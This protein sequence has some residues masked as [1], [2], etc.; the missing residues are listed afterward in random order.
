MEDLR[1][2]FF[3]YAI[4]SLLM[5]VACCRFFSVKFNK[6]QILLVTL[7]YGISIWLVRGL[8]ALFHIPY[9]SHSLI[10]AFIFCMLLL[11]ITKQNLIYC[12]GMTC[13]SFSLVFLGGGLV[14]IG[15]NLTGLTEEHIFKNIWL[16]V[17]FGQLENILLVI[18]LTFDRIIGISLNSMVKEI[19]E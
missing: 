2:L 1:V 9:G 13:F 10:L 14:G 16:H 3:F 7:S 17:I 6:H 19:H 15:L 12:L 8:Y 5:T 11:V 18:Y 4:Q